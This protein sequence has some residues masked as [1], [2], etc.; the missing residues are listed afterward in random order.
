MKNH[1][2]LRTIGLLVTVCAA[3][4]MAGCEMPLISNNLIHGS[5]GDGDPFASV[6]IPGNVRSLSVAAGAGT[7]SFTWV[8]PEDEDF[9]YIE[10]SCVEPE[11]GFE[12]REVAK[13]EQTVKI[14]GLENGALYDSLIQTVDTAGTK[15]AGVRKSVVVGTDP[16]PA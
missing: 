6:A 13:G 1:A 16:L 4:I 11:G 8:D 7:A 5:A 15:S 14:A 3:A 2:F 10:I 9:D 12:P